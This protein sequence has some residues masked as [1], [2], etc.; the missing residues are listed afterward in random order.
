MNTEEFLALASR[1]SRI[2]SGPA[3]HQNLILPYRRALFRRFSGIRYSPAAVL[4]LFYPKDDEMYTVLIERPQYDGV[5][6]GQ[7]A[8][9]GGKKEP[10]DRSLYETA[11]RETREE[12]GITGNDITPLRRLTAV[13]IPVSAYKVTPFAAYARHTPRFDPDPREVRRVLEIPLEKLLRTPW[14]KET[15]YYENRPY[16]VYYL[17]F[18]AHK[19]WGATAMVIAE[20]RDL[21][22]RAQNGRLPGY[23]NRQIK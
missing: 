5:H 3:Y 4:V 18:G 11:V 16:T 12:L 8:F 23:A 10:F 21:F 1:F 6:S 17:P 20:L 13:K 15:R 19:I 7:I 9:P 22:D 14:E 2:P